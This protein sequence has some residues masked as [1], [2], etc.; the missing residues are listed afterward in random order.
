MHSSSGGSIRSQ[1][2]L[3]NKAGCRN[4]RDTA[5]RSV[6]TGAKLDLN[7]CKMPDR[8]DEHITQYHCTPEKP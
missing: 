1:K 3:L 5:D 2:T 8:K 6:T 7:F 4:K